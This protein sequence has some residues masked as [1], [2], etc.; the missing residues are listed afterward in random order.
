MIFKILFLSLPP[1]FIFFL[2]IKQNVWQR[3]KRIENNLGGSS[4]ILKFSYVNALQWRNQSPSE[5]RAAAQLK[6]T[7]YYANFN[8]KLALDLFGRSRWRFYLFES[9][10]LTTI[11]I[12]LL[13]SSSARR[14]SPAPSQMLRG[15][16]VAAGRRMTRMGRGLAQGKGSNSPPQISS[17]L[18]LVL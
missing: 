7:H 10:K 18:V 6:I 17:I 8:L 13:R 5:R 11:L 2:F 9:D 12:L 16:R 14:V 15:S 3:F 4:A 1:N